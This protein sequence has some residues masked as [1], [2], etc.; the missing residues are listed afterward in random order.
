MRSRP[1]VIRV[2]VFC[3]LAVL[4]MSA[5]STGVRT[6][7][8]DGHNPEKFAGNEVALVQR[9]M[10]D[11]EG[12]QLA[13]WQSTICE[14]LRDGQTAQSDC[15]FHL[16]RCIIVLSHPPRSIP[17]ATK[18]GSLGVSEGMGPAIGCKRDGKVGVLTDELFPYQ[19]ESFRYLDDAIQYPE[20]R[21]TMLVAV[22][23]KRSGEQ[24]KSTRIV[25][26][27]YSWT[28]RDWNLKEHRI[29]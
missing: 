19:Y 24:Q 14:L 18:V 1:A 28:H 9:L 7:V 6:E 13:E 17:V 3:G 4:V 23:A 22:E 5:C 2:T 15:K 21:V 26:L 11:Y 16:V 8:P 27:V 25:I 29:F 10:A 20:A 12:R